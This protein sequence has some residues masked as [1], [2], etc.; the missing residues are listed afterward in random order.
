MK[1]DLSIKGS[2]HLKRIFST[3]K[4]NVEPNYFINTLLKGKGT[5]SENQ[6]L[7]TPNQTYLEVATK[8]ADAKLTTKL[9]IERLLSSRIT[10]LLKNLSTY[11]RTLSEI[12]TWLG[13]CMIGE[14]LKLFHENQQQD[15]TICYEANSSINSYAR[16]NS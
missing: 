12:S 4:T 5:L 7:I 10:N 16:I 1:K 13:L 3:V 14:A 6:K 15:I 2:T 11:I 9:N 8:I